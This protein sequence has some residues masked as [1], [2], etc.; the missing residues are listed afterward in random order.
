MEEKIKKNKGFIQIPLL[1]GVIISIVVASGIGYGAVEYQKTS[2]LVKESEQLAQEEKYNEATEKLKVA[3]D[4]WL[5]KNLS[6]K[7]Q[8]ISNKIEENRNLLED[9]SK[10]NQGLSELD[11]GNLQGAINLFSEILEQSFYYQKTQTKIEEVRRKMVEEELGE[12]KIAKEEAEEKA[13][14]EGE[15]KE[16]AEEKAKQEEVARKVAEEK[17]KEEKETR[18]KAEEKMRQEEMAKIEAKE[19]AKKEKIAREATEQ[20]LAEK[21][22]EEKELNADKDGDGLTYRQELDLGTSDLNI[23]SDGDGIPDGEDSHPAGGGRLLIS[24]HFEWDYNGSHWQ[25]DHSFPSDWWDYYKDKEHG[26]HGADYVTYS[27]TYI[28]NIADML[29][30]TADENNYSASMFTM[31]FI[32]SLGYVGDEVIGYD[33]FPKYP[34]E[35]LAEQNGDCEDTSYLAAAIISAM[36]ISCVLVELPNHM[37][38]AIAFSDSPGGYYYRL[39]NGWDYYYIETTEEGWKLGEIPDDFRYTPATLVKIPSGETASVYP[40]YKKL[41][42]SSIYYPSYYYSEGN[43]YRDS[44]CQNLITCFPL[45]D[46]P[47]YYWDVNKKELYW[48]SSCTQI[49]VKGCSKSTNYS[50]YFTNGIDYY[51]DSR[52]TQKARICRPSS[53]YSDRYWDGEY[54]YWDISCTQKV[55]SWCS[56]ST[57][58]P[59]YFFN[60]LDYEYYLDNICSIPVLDTTTPP[61]Y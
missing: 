4:K 10:Y 46:Y 11:K 3:Q 8:E 47:D 17:T 44:Q 15:A 51:S 20:E 35:T 53:I 52:C 14:Q 23:D 49:V 40:N 16:K 28:K 6:I 56:K 25:W 19:K 9:Q 22:A 26:P 24:Q 61:I 57:Y 45:S 48:D 33:D 31:A 7:K 29:K 30:K 13:R 50:G 39:S 34:L 42:E 59:G 21:E 55:A 60:S 1:V 12:T 54:N 38:V 58:H 2:K 5:V 41:C 43:Y 32:Q 18:E 37:A 36:N 27:N